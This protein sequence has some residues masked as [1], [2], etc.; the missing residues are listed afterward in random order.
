MRY[1]WKLLILLLTISILPGL[2]V[3]MFGVGSVRRLGSVLTSKSRESLVQH[4]ENRM[5]MLVA[6]YSAVLEGVREQIE[7]ALLFQATEVERAL[8][9]E[10]AGAPGVVY[11]SG[12]FNQG[13]HLPPDTTISSFHFRLL[14]KGQLKLLNVSYAEQVFKVA[15][16]VS[17]DDVAADIARLSELTSVYRDLAVQMKRLVWWQNTTLENGL[18]TSFPGHNG[19]P[20]RLDARKMS[21][22]KQ[23]FENYR[24]WSEPYVDP[25]TRQ[26]VVAATKP[27]RRP[28]GK[29]YGITAIVLP[30]SSFFNRKPLF[31]QMPPGTQP[32]ICYPAKN[33]ETGREDIR[34][35]AREEQS[36][37]DHRSWRVRLE[38]GWLNGGDPDQLGEMLSDLGSGLSNTRKMPF[39]NV[40]SLWV[41]GKTSTP[42][43]ACLVLIM[44]YEEILRPVV[45]SETFIDEQ[46]NRLIKMVGYIGFGVI[47]L[48]VILAFTF[49]RTVTKPIRIMIEGARKLAAGHFD[50]RVQ[51]RSRDEFGEMAR[52]FN[53]IGPQ[54]KENYDIKHSLELAMEVQQNLLPSTDPSVAGLDIAGRS[55]YCEK[56]GGDYFDYLE[57]AEQ[58]P[59]RVTVVVG[60][61]SDHGIPSAL[62]MTTARAMLRQRSSRAGSIHEIVTDVNRQLTR[63]T[64][65]SGQFMTLFYCEIDAGEKWIR[66]VRAGHDPVM[67]YDPAG[68]SFRL[69]LGPGVA[70]G[71]LGNVA[72]EENHRML[73]SGQIILIGTDGIWEAHSAEGQMYGKE[74]LK[75]I[76]RE[77]VRASAKDIVESVLDSLQTFVH[78]LNLE[79]DVTLVVVK[80]V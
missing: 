24:L 58:V 1:R 15:R 57:R 46:V 50:T 44:P 14:P 37:L 80:V 17:P 69:L 45:A 18:H 21:W 16:G 25:E 52:I 36:D 51:I 39:E 22:Y 60:D 2:F 9:L 31:Q 20:Y 63:D 35:F 5:Q 75:K 23:A 53:R 38:A 59:G 66:W 41:Y 74:A 6:S 12:D 56:T 8:A 49:S 11:F 7:T 32:F 3:R 55:L 71:V 33:P 42:T 28:D 19:I 40:E 73:S 62:L 78:P 68:D 64:Q 43:G 67:V 13:E 54:L 27:V 34:I 48:V 76:I 79:D 47:I 26:I 61:V 4:M 29:A 72:Y 10:N 30:I 65:E 70:M 77:N